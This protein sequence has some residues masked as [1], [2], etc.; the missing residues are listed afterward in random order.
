MTDTKKGTGGAYSS[1]IKN[2]A[3]I[4][5]IKP[6][7]GTSYAVEFLTISLLI[8]DLQFPLTL[9]PISQLDKSRFGEYSPETLNWYAQ[10]IRIALI[11]MNRGF[12]DPELLKALDQAVTSFL[13]HFRRTTS[14]ERSSRQLY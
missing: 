14:Y 5:G 6:Q 9:Y 2:T 3:W 11:L 10:H 13:Y 7:Q 1:S 4:V 12:N 8:K